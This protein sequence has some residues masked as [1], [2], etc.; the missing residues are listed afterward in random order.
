MIH[1]LL[2]ILI[3]PQIRKDLS[4]ITKSEQQMTEQAKAIWKAPNRMSLEDQQRNSNMN[5]RPAEGI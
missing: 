3:H 5:D 1:D 2:T 4:W